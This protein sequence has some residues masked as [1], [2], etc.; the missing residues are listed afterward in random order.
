MINFSILWYDEFYRINVMFTLHEYNLEF[1][2]YFIGN[3]GNTIYII[4]N[5]IFFR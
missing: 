2:R 1:Q 4:I 5:A 3:I